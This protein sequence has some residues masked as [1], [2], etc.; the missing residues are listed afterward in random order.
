MCSRSLARS[1]D[2]LRYGYEFFYET[3]Y[4][5][6]IRKDNRHNF[7]V[8][9]YHIY[10]STAR[11]T[12]SPAS[13]PAISIVDSSKSAVFAPSQNQPDF[14]PPGNEFLN[15]PIALESSLGNAEAVV[16]DSLFSMILILALDNIRNVIVILSRTNIQAILLFF[17]QFALIV[18]FS[19]LYYR[20]IVFCM[21]VNTLAFVALNKV[22]TV[23]V[24]QFL[25]LLRIR[26][27]LTRFSILFG[28]FRCCHWCARSL[29]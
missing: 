6:I 11:A 2:H 5:H 14:A 23:Q 8:Y 15:A 19:F 27:H 17:P 18:G 29:G 13:T 24:C 21:F 28:I 4:Y 10:L 25:F 3:Y 22:C 20:Y 9:F 7:S 12:L 26:I 16:S 1:A